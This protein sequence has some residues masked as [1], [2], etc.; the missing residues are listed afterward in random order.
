MSSPP[1]HLCL[2]CRRGMAETEQLLQ[3]GLAEYDRLS[4]DEQGQFAQLVK[5]DDATLLVWLMHPHKAPES[6]RPLIG[7]IRRHAR[8][9]KE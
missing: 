1:K 3:V 9:H 7:K 5:Q 4:V 6:L 2:A 8:S